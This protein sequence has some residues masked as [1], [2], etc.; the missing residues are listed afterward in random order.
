M[1]TWRTTCMRELN[2]MGRIWDPQRRRWSSWRQVES[3]IVVSESSISLR[4]LTMSKYVWSV[5]AD[6]IMWLLSDCLVHGSV[7]LSSRRLCV[8]LLSYF[9]C[10]CGHRLVEGTWCDRL[11]LAPAKKSVLTTSFPSGFHTVFRACCCNMF[12]LFGTSGGGRT[13]HVNMFFGRRSRS[14]SFGHTSRLQG[15]AALG[16]VPLQ[17][18]A[19]PR[20][21]FWRRIEVLHVR[22]LCGLHKG[23]T[24]VCFRI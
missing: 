3:L 8:S 7:H 21:S 24:V 16:A 22:E 5:T 6:F 15:L 10:L 1:S 12:V 23:L 11:H 18:L 19:N 17:V 14:H 13:T 4:G 2:A 9:C 20:W